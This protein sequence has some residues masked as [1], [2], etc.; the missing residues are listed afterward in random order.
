MQK[1]ALKNEIKKRYIKSLNS[2]LLNSIDK[3]FTVKMLQK[4]LNVYPVL[5]LLWFSNRS[6]THTSCEANFEQPWLHGLHPTY[7]WILLLTPIENFVWQKEIKAKMLMKINV[8]P[9][10]VEISYMLISPLYYIIFYNPVI[11]LG[12]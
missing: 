10:K 1:K 4:F 6:G 3:I 12:V 9:L 8:S 5:M 2:L 7:F 11:F